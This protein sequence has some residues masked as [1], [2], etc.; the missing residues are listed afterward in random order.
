MSRFTVDLPAPDLLLPA[1]R[2]YRKLV[3]SSLPLRTS[4]FPSPLFVSRR[5]FS[6]Y[7]YPSSPSVPD[8]AGLAPGSIDDPVPS[9]GASHS[10][11]PSE[12][13]SK[14]C[15]IKN[16]VVK[17]HNV[18]AAPVIDVQTDRVCGICRIC[19]GDVVHKLRFSAS[20]PINGLFLVPH[21]EQCAAPAQ[22][23]ICQNTNILPLQVVRVLKFVD[24]KMGV[25]LRKGVVYFRNKIF[26]RDHLLEEF[27]QFLYQNESMPT[28]DIPSQPFLEK[29]VD[30]R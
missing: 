12:G 26:S 25:A 22:C 14:F 6:T 17:S 8:I 9:F 20:P 19:G 21:E 18:L 10:R 4:G 2:L 11:L 1:T 3:R 30:S 28:G 16:G 29:S 5:S 15:R 27:V 7:T 24:E 23:L 13:D